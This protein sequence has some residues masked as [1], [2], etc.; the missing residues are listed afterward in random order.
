MSTFSPQQVSKE[1]LGA[2]S[3]RSR[4]I[5][6]GRYGLGRGGEQLTLEAIGAR[7]G[8]TRER[9]R[10][11]ESQSIIMI[12]KSDAYRAQ[13]E[14]FKHL[15]ESLRELGG[16][17]SQQDAVEALTRRSTEQPHILFLLNVGEP[18]TYHKE[19][20]HFTH[21]WHVD[22]ELAE[23]VHTALETLHDELDP[24]H[25]IPENEFI[26]M[27]L[28]HLQKAGLNK[29][30]DEG[31]LKRWLRLSRKIARNPLGEWGLAHSSQVRVKSMRDYAYL[32]LKRHGTPLHFTEV[33]STIK[34]LFKRD[35]HP[36]TCHNE[37]IK[38]AR[39]VLVG[40]G[41]YALQEWGYKP[42]VVR[43]VIVE[44]LEASGPLTRQQ[45][46]EQVRRERYVRENTILVNL[47][48]PMF[49]RTKDGKYALAK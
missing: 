49:K 4:D 39:F 19:A 6:V 41:L 32:T 13:Q 31:M 40:R 23:R 1:L 3:P 9:V 37:L 21:R 11:I 45:I 24:E 44:V 12:R 10:Q 38:D 35:A 30:T 36:A 28:T 14:A 22:R 16:I 48:D 25:I 47:Q 33:A 34:K 18:F 46:V 42:G 20:G 17:V 8:I 15:E 27:F 29:K 5:V 26:D 43:D 7:Y 2:L